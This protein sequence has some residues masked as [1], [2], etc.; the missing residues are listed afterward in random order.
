MKQPTYN[1]L[2]RLPHVIQLVKVSRKSLYC[3]IHGG[4]KKYLQRW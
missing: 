2:L 3:I 4:I 1:G